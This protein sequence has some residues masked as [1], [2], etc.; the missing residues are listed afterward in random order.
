MYAGKIGCLYQTDL[1]KKNHF[2]SW[3]LPNVGVGI[4]RLL[5]YGNRDE[6][7]Q[8]KVLNELNLPIRWIIFAA[9][10]QSNE[11]KQ[12]KLNPLQRCRLSGK[13]GA[14]GVSGKLHFFISDDLNDFK[15]VIED[16][17]WDEG[18]GISLP[19]EVWDEEQIQYAVNIQIGMRHSLVPAIRHVFHCDI[20][21]HTDADGYNVLWDNSFR[22]ASQ[23]DAWAKENANKYP[24]KHDL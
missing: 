9:S 15:F 17:L 16:G 11:F 2:D 7:Y 8:V 12:Y 4:H 24:W 23:I 21:A 13:G 5:I 14:T 10:K 6:E 19:S 18:V 20:V 1:I 22:F 3:G